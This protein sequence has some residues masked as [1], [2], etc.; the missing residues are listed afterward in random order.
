MNETKSVHLDLRITQTERDKIKQLA[1]LHNLSV[2]AYVR[3]VLLS[4]G[5]A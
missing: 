4:G 3:M 1:K 5:E 2:S